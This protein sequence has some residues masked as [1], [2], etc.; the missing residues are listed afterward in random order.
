MTTRMSWLDPSKV[1][2]YRRGQRFFL[3][4]AAAL[5]LTWTAARADIFYDNTTSPATNN[6]FKT[7]RWLETGDEVLLS[8]CCPVILTNF[9]LE[10]FGTNF[11]GNEQLRLRFYQQGATP[12]KLGNMVYDSG[13]LPIA[14][15]PTGALLQFTDFLTGAVVPLTNPLPVDFTWSVQFQGIETG[16]VAGLATSVPLA[17]RYTFLLPDAVRNCDPLP[18]PPS[19][20]PERNFDTFWEL[21]PNGWVRA[22]PAD[23]AQRITPIN[24]L[25]RIEGEIAGLHFQRPVLREGES[26]L[27]LVGESGRRYRI[28]GSP[29][30]AHW[31][32]VRTDTAVDR[33][34][35]V[36][37]PAA[38][39]SQFYRAVLLE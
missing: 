15:A 28:E 6:H 37:V 29:D 22:L 33:V 18:C 32:E 30:F 12:D 9:V 39:A 11:S 7:S 24:F 14:P 25:A 35:S 26:V 31:S 8:A 23:D 2:I 38:A 19:P 21:M 10:Y 36:T 20:P 5:V 13:W 16:E 3:L 4:V 17:P 27:T 34:L 1:K